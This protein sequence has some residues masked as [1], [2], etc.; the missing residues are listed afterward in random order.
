[1]EVSQLKSVQTLDNGSTYSARLHC[2]KHD[3]TES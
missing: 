1:M 3:L 2:S